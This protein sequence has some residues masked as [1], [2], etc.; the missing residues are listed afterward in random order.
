[1]RALSKGTLRF[2]IAF[3]FFGGALIVSGVVASATYLLADTYLTRQRADSLVR[4]SFNS[5]R[6]ATEYLARPEPQRSTDE[7]VSF[8]KAR[9][10]A[11]ILVMDG[12]RAVA[13]SVSLVPAAIPRE[14]SQAV[15]E[16][17]VAY[18]STGE[19]PRSFVFG[20]PIPRSNLDAYFVY[21]L[22]DLDDTL[23]LLAR[24]LLGV[25]GGTVLL[26]GVLGFR[27]AARTIE[28]LRRASEAAQQ[29][30]EG[31]LETRLEET[32]DDELGTMAASF[33]SMARAL[34]ERI[35][36]ERQFVADASH[37]LRTP[38]TALKTS[39]DFLAD[40]CDDLPPRMRSIVSLAAEEVRS[41]QRLVDDLLELSRVEAGGVHVSWED[42]DLGA[43]A[44]EVARRRAPGRPVYV[45]SPDDGLVVRTDKARLER[46]V[47]NLLE[48]AIVHGN[49]QDVQIA[50]EQLDGHAR[51]MVADR[52]PGIEQENLDRIFERFWRADQSRRR[53]RT[54]GAGLGLA[55]AREN[56]HVLG[57]D[58]E[59]ESSPGAG[60]RFTVLLPMAGEG[61]Q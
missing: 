15:E 2:R 34:Q 6:F 11:E 32:G 49:G 23:W 38:L 29:V 51:V 9:G 5:L 20:S 13:S 17:R 7:L 18:I 42:V 50:V 24:I 39:V 3:A 45:T 1:M 57:A 61:A 31:L 8:L 46:V 33:N 25:V 40:H 60:T 55:I 43:F 30:A 59:V 4:Q 47:G 27:L 21:S 26:A 54:T 28:P 16:E 48:N 36:R 44:V 41:L 56:A 12:D 35:S 58:L 37:E 22:E 53:G 52:G 19:T 10:T 14:L